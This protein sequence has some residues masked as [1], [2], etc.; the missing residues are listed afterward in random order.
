MRQSTL[1]ENM[2]SIKK[3]HISS[4]PE[5]KTVRSLRIIEAGIKR[6]GS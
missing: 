3:E 2:L 4:R 1:I 5:I 6:E